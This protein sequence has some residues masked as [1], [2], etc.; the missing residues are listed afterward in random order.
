MI[1][2]TMQDYQ[3]TIGAS[4]VMLDVPRWRAAFDHGAQPDES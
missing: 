4:D 1:R 3:L 2:S